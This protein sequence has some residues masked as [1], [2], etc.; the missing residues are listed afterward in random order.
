M[1][2]KGINKKIWIGLGVLIVA[3]LAALFYVTRIQPAEGSKAVTVEV[4]DS[5]GQSTMY[6]LKTDAAYLAEVMDEADGLSYEAEEGEYGLNVL[7][8]N[9]ERAIYA[10]DGSYWAFYVNGEYCNYGISEQ[11]VEDGDAFQIVYTVSE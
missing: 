11:P 7:S 4:V 3:V 5:Q 2:K 9:G 10:E 1:E 8:V 6:E